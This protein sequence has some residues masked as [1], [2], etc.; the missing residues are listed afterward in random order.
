MLI[1]K[2]YLH[3]LIMGFPKNK[4][5]DHINGNKLD[6]RKSNLRICTQRQ[7][8]WN[9]IK[10]ELGVSSKYKGVHFYKR[11]GKWQSSIQAGKRL[12][13]GFFDT[14]KEAAKAYDFMAKKLRGEYANTNGI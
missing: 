14:E 13:L 10:K 12:H 7:N 1:K 3:R 4:I 8:A 2:V 6:N 9:S 11:T 5:V